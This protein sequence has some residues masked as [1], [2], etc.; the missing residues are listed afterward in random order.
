MLQCSALKWRFDVVLQ[1][2][3]RC[4]HPDVLKWEHHATLAAEFFNCAPVFEAVSHP[5]TEGVRQC[6]HWASRRFMTLNEL[7]TPHEVQTPGRLGVRI[8]SRR[9][10]RRVREP[11]YSIMA[12][13]GLP[14]Q[15]SIASQGRGRI[16][17]WRGLRRGA[18]SASWK[19]PQVR[20]VPMMLE[21][22]NS[23][24]RRPTS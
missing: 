13:C 9:D 3:A 6:S 7:H 17:W 11:T 14:K 1:P 21:Q 2:D 12:R 15:P 18:S 23:S 5:C 20:T 19:K 16:A 10:S 24:S 22:A 8:A 4:R